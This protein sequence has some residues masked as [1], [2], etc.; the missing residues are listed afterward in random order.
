MILYSPRLPYSHAPLLLWICLISC[1]KILCPLIL[2]PLTISPIIYTSAEM[3]LFLTTE[4]RV[5]Y[6][7][8][9]SPSQESAVLFL[10]YVK[11]EI[12][13]FFVCCPHLVSDNT[14]SAQT[15]LACPFHGILQVH[16]SVPGTTGQCHTILA[17]TFHFIV[18]TPNV[19]WKGKI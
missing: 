18:K 3:G 17:R 7:Q 2:A 1:P 4:F 9:K 13:L 15:V 6:P 16:R 19:H 12:T 8:T 10:Q 14:K 11:S 5:F